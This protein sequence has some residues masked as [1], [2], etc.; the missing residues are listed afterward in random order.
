MW[1]RRFVGA[2]DIH[3]DATV[4]HYASQSAI[5]L[6]NKQGNHGR[7]KH[8]AIRFHYI[9]EDVHEGMVT[10]KKKST[11][12]NPADMLTKPNFVIMF[13]HFLDLINVQ[14]K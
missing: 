5:H 8:I 11:S 12:E 6:V 3:Q 4:V 7:T 13:K 9:W 14:K 2:L 1:L 10:L